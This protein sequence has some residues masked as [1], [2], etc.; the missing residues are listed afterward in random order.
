[1]LILTFAIILGLGISLTVFWGKL[2]DWLNG[3]FRTWIEKKF[4]EAVG[5]EFGKFLGWLDKKMDIPRKA[6][7]EMLR[8]IKRILRIKTTY[9]KNQD[10]T[11][12]ST[13]ESV[14]VDQHDTTIKV[15]E[16]VVNEEDI[17]ID[18]SIRQEMIR[19]RTN[20]AEMDEKEIWER[21]IK[22][23]AE[24][25]GFSDIMTLEY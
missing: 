20:V 16:T 6:L 25:D 10:G 7:R 14:F 5:T 8:F 12:N 22:E 23:R 9:T 21:K 24:E 3:R 1:M 18:A 15:T 17:D 11:F 19:Q 13:R 2:R 4:G